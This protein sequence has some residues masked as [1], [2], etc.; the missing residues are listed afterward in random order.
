VRKTATRSASTSSTSRAARRRL[1]VAPSGE[2]LLVD[3]GWPG[4]EGRDAERIAAV[5]R[6]AGIS[7]IDSS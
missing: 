7:S 4:F 5:A 6:T 3:A 1:F 2:S